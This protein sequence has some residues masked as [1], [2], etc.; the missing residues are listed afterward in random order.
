MRQCSCGTIEM[1]TVQELTVPVHND[2]KTK[3]VHISEKEDK[4]RPE[5]GYKDRE[6]FK[7]R[8]DEAAY[9]KGYD[10][11]YEEGYAGR[12]GRYADDDEK[13]PRGPVVVKIAAFLVAALLLVVA[14]GHMSDPGTYDGTITSLDDTKATVMK[15]AGATTAASTAIT[16]LPGDA[17]TPI[18]EQLAELSGYFVFIYSAIYVEKYLTTTGGLIAFR[19]LL[20]IALLLL[21]YAA[22][23]REDE[24]AGKLRKLGRNLLIFGLA[25][26]MVVPCSVMISKHIEKTYDD[27]VN[28]TLVQSEQNV[29]DINEKAEE[30]SGDEGVLEKLIDKTKEKTEGTLEKFQNTLNDMLDGIAMLIVTTC[31]IPIG[32]LIFLVWVMK[33]LFGVNL[34][35]PSP[36]GMGRRAFRKFRG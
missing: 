5:D 34:N 14:S 9:E 28:D 22:F 32:V 16:L 31:V 7:G 18:A 10:D 6:E 21:A 30:A 19:F 2:G 35:L 1:S 20:P 11:G 26:W 4:M 27:S 23:R 24:W 12:Y 29:N 17:G 13:R 25:L 33:M 3:P 36:R 15:M 8:A